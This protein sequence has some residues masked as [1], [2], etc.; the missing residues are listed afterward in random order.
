MMSS[1]RYAMDATRCQ[2]RSHLLGATLRL[3]KRSRRF[4]CTQ[5]SGCIDGEPNKSEGSVGIC[6]HRF[7][8]LATAGV[9]IRLHGV[10][11]EGEDC[12]AVLTAVLAFCECV[13]E[14]MPFGQR[15][16]RIGYATRRKKMADLG[17]RQPFTGVSKGGCDRLK[18]T[19][20]EER[21]HAFG[22]RSHRRQV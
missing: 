5:P 18:L 19:L 4:A 22:R 11:D 2:V 7:E 9:M 14:A 12:S 6:T 17:A 20:T 16:R 21:V 1:T 15:L 13:V 3:R 10:A 8:A